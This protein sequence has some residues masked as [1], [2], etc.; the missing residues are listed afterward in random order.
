MKTQ[1]E[2]HFVDNVIGALRKTAIEL[3]A[4]QVQVALGKAEAKDKYAE[5]KKRYN[6]FIH[7]SEYKIEGVKD[8]IEELHMKFDELRVQ[9]ALG[10]ADTKE[11][12]EEQKKQLHKTIHD[13]EVK[14]KTNDTLNSMYAFALIELEQFK[15]QLEILEQRFSENKDKAKVLFEK[16]RDNFNAFIAKMKDK[17]SGKKEMTQFEHFQYEI[18]E[19]F[20]HFKNAFSKS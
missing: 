4:F 18:S 6:A 2:S 16:G 5:M 15:I 10:K 1:N 20:D 13:I 12:F 9:L 8:K 19:A 7:D 17:Y 3:E 14:I 11:L